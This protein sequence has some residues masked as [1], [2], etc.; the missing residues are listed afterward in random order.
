MKHVRRMVAAFLTLCL[1][2]VCFI[3]INKLVQ[4]KDSIITYNDFYNDG[5]EYDV[6]LC[7][8]SHMLNTVYPMELWREYGISSYNIANPTEAVGTTYWVL[9]NALEYKK[10][11]VAIVEIF[12]ATDSL[13]SGGNETFLHTY[14]DSVP[15]SRT[16]VEAIRELL[17]DK[18]K[19]E[20]LFDFSL[21][22]SRWEELGKGDFEWDKNLNKGA[23][24]ISTHSNMGT[25][26][27]TD[28]IGKTSDT[29]VKYIRKMKE[30]CDENG[31][32]LVLMCSPY[33]ATE[34]EQ[35]KH[36][37]YYDVAKDLGV[38]YLNYIAKDIVDYEIDMFDRG[39]C[40]GAGGRRVTS[41]VGEYL[42]DT[43]G[44][45][46]FVDYSNDEKWQS[47]YDDYANNMAEQML[48]E[49]GFYNILMRLQ[50]NLFQCDITIKEGSVLLEDDITKKML[51]RLDNGDNTI[52][53][54]KDGEC[55]IIIEIKKSG[56][57]EI[58][59]T[60][61][62][63]TKSVLAATAVQPQEDE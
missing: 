37:A 14:F 59:S 6:L 21:Y 51:E 40:N 30:L 50:H 32:E 13:V 61:R 35:K 19:A 29:S 53:Y 63:D 16:K 5:L 36:N 18:D 57:D 20:F 44:K 4:K 39:H 17:G 46:Y 49:N 25:I 10:P 41:K 56:K 33:A 7:G 38:D 60:K 9:K 26:T 45:D 58:I 15:L 27:Y 1:F 62:F 34:D 2:M 28:E 48:N 47:E 11:K 42:I 43:Y 52:R 8:S 31:V 3:S 54:V 24:V 12:M 22:H 23:G 55:D